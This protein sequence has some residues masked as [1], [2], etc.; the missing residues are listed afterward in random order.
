MAYFLLNTVFQFLQWT[1]I[2]HIDSV[3]ES[4]TDNNNTDLNVDI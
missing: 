4:P 1:W 2:V 3:P